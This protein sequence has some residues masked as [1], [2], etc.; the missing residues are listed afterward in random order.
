MS[1]HQ[2]IATP[3]R[4]PMIRRL[5]LHWRT[6]LIFGL[7]ILGALV[8][9]APFAWLFS[10]SLRPA[11]ETFALPPTWF[12]TQFDLTNYFNLFKRDIPLVN[13]YKNSVVVSIVCAFGITATSAMAGYA[14]AKLR[15]PFRDGLFVL[16]L[17][18]LMVPVQ[19]TIVPLFIMMQRLGLVDTFW[20]LTLP[21]LTGAFAPGIP[22]AFGIFMMRQFFSRT[23]DA[24]L[25]AAKIDGAGPWTIFYR[26]ALPLAMPGVTA[27][28]VIT[29]T[30]TWN[31]F[32]LPLVFLTSVDNMVLPVG[33]IAL[34]EP[35]TSAAWTLSF[36]ALAILPLLLIFLVAQRW[37]IESFSRSGI[38]E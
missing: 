5:G 31:D 16:L 29:L 27:L 36:V 4:R 11:L 14:F 12:P 38:R 3:L 22:A 28:A 15:F 33:I 24:L 34:R 32:F 25:E 6:A 20:S 35:F 30:L 18:A 21:A 13:L 19:V 23:P 10:T 37:I 9:V 1:D 17:L 8:M 2:I 7:L 26:I